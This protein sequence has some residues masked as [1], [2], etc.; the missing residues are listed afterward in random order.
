MAFDPI[1]GPESEAQIDWHR[2][3]HGEAFVRGWKVGQPL[4]GTRTPDWRREVPAKV[5]QVAEKPESAA[6]AGG[7]RRNRSRRMT[8]G[9][10]APISRNGR[11][12]ERR[13]CAAYGCDRHVTVRR[14]DARYCSPAC[15]QRAYRERQT[16]L[17]EEGAPA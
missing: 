10:G 16:S 11:P 7:D 17:F 1:Y 4:S 6:L 14:A 8:S 15:R 5:D 9:T 13:T 2:R 3:E 12:P